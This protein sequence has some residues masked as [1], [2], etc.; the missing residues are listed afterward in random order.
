MKFVSPWA[1][2]LGSSFA[3]IQEETAKKPTGAISITKAM[4]HKLKCWSVKLQKTLCAVCMVAK[5]F[6]CSLHRNGSKHTK[7]IKM[8][9]SRHREPKVPIRMEICHVGL[10]LACRQVFVDWCRSTIETA[11]AARC[12]LR[13]M[14]EADVCTS[15][16]QRKEQGKQKSSS[17]EICCWCQAGKAIDAPQRTQQWFHGK[18]V[19]E[20]QNA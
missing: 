12:G 16:P 17:Q 1:T 15:G 2:R 3:R 18:D 4:M 8:K 9:K 11:L 7:Q 5:P 19:E 14:N 6:G 10:W 13:N 20:L